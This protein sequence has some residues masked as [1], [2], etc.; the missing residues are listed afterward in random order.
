[1]EK[2]FIKKHLIDSINEHRGSDGWSSL[3]KIGK[4]LM[5]KGVDYKSLGYEKLFSLVKEHKDC[6]SWRVDDTNPKFPIFYVR[7]K[8]TAEK[9]KYKKL[10]NAKKDTSINIDP[11]NALTTW[12]SLGN[13]S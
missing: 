1:M 6:I 11:V 13:F 10:L 3:L 4:S 12:A 5:N 7:E 2:S 9:A 8:S